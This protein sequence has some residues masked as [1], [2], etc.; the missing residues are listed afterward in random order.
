MTIAD[1]RPTPRRLI[2]PLGLAICLSLFGDLTLYTVLPSRRDV[3]GLSLASVGIML[4]ANRLIRIPGNPIVGALYD[5][6]GRRKLFILGMTLA[7]L[8]TFGYSLLSGFLPFLLTRLTWGMAWTL[9][10]VG[11]IAMIHDVSTAA[12]RGRLSG[13]YN[14]WMLAGFAIGPLLGGFL[15]DQ[16]GFRE[17]MRLYAAITAAGWLV[18]VLALPETH[19]RGPGPAAVPPPGA[20]IGA[21]LFQLWERARQLLAADRQLQAVLLLVLLFQFAGEGVALSTFNLLLERRFGATLQ[22][23]GLTLG[24]ASATGILAVMRSLIAG[25]AGPIAGLI[26]DR[27]HSRTGVLAAS[28]IL[29]ILGFGLL[30]VAETLPLILVAVVLSAFSAGGG[31]AAL[32]AALGDRAAGHRRGLLVGAYATAGDTGSALGPLIAYPLATALP[33]SSAYLLCAAAFTAGLIYLA[34]LPAPQPRSC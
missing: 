7:V 9:L 14:A 22:L 11:G 5:R 30:G 25:G 8:S 6:I 13:A 26:A 2:L 16:F 29:G 23:G 17:T 21:G 10:N 1:R 19:Q 20:P 34:A 32:T 27:R 12:N 28:L 33:L 4:G 3:V 15:V 24:V 18:A 31:M